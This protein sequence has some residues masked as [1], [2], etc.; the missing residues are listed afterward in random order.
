[1]AAEVWGWSIWVHYWQQSSIGWMHRC[2]ELSI[3]PVHPYVI[4][5]SMCQ[6]CGWNPW[7]VS[8]VTGKPRKER[9]SCMFLGTGHFSTASTFEG[10]IFEY[11]AHWW[12][13]AHW[14]CG[15]RNSI[16]LVKN[17]HLLAWHIASCLVTLGAPAA[18]ACNDHLRGSGYLFLIVILLSAR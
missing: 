10:S 8:V 5:M 13:D 12:C 7:Q 18:G 4:V 2:G 6:L 16:S 14:W 15:P 1:M 3:H 11:H 9:S 17:S